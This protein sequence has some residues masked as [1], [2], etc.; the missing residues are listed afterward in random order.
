MDEDALVATA[1]ATAMVTDA[2]EAVAKT[3]MDEE[4]V[5]R[6]GWGVGVPYAPCYS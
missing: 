2:E 4:A 3:A 6:G 1:M 5:V